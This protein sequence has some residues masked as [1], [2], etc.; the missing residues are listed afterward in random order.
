MKNDVD[1]GGELVKEA[2][3]ERVRAVLRG[4]RRLADSRDRF[5]IEARRALPSATGLSAAN[6]ELSLSRHLETSIKPEGMERLLVRAGSAPRVHVVLSANV[7]VGVVRA[8]ALAAAA[9]PSVVVRPSSREGVLAPLLLEAIKESG[10][11]AFF[12]LSNELE[13]L[14]G[15]HVHVYGRHETIRAIADRCQPGVTVR[16][17]GPGFGVAVV[18]VSPS[19]ARRSAE[20][21]SWDIVAFDQRG[22]LSPRLALVEGSV[23]NASYFA[24]CLASELASREAEVPRGALSDDECR[25]AA[26]YRQTLD[27]VGTHRGGTS[28]AVGLDLEPSA[29]L[30]PPTGR[31][32][33]LLRTGDVGLLER[34]LGPCRNAITCFGVSETSPFAERLAEL[35]PGAR[36]LP[37]GNMQSPPLDG[38][39]D[40]REML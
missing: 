22:C 18:R 20:R 13:P 35:A 3:A 37:L 2:R 6:V 34:L 36:I 4:A 31:H 16:G 5:G 32:I 1:G 14:P 33:H 26:L 10:S 7:F 28:F 19:D 21:L 30:L 38:P 8:V 24:D 39:V 27:A 40:L 25:D 23:D 9:A 12:A 11:A 15:D 29:V 17:H